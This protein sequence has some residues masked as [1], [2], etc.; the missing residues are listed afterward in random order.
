MKKVLIILIVC[1]F[2]PFKVNAISASSAIVMDADSNRV[3]WGSNINEQR[4][5]ASITKIM[6]AIVTL[7]NV[8]IN[9]KVIVDERV[10]KAYGSA[11]YITI[12]EEITIKDLLYGLMLRSG[13]DAALV[14]KIYFEDENKDLVKLMNEKAKKLNMNNTIFV[15]PHGLEENDGSANKST[16]YDM[17]LLMSYAMKNKEFRQ[18]V[19]TKSYTAKTNQKS[20]TWKNKNKLLFNYEYCNGGKTGFTKLAK[21]TLVTSATKDN[22]NLVVVTLNDGNDFNDHKELYEKYFK[23]YDSLKIIDKDKFKILNES[24]YRGVKFYVKND[25]KILVTEQ[26]K[27]NVKLNIV[28]EKNENFKDNQVIGKVQVLLNNENI[29]EEKIY[30]VRKSSIKKESLWTKI[31]N[32]FK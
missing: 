20:Y 11:I 28:L 30:I 10:L 21:R 9:K 4:L 26:E 18:I 27:N 2:I 13:N 6:T 16:S 32:W 5:I 14:I 15:N 12:G 31:K 8:D 17:A 23:E 7:E 1:L 29:H 22:K 19:S 3:L 25:F 24:Y